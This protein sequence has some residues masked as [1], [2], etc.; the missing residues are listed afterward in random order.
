M[1]D[2]QTLLTMV[3]PRAV[4]RAVVVLEGGV[5]RRS[6]CR[7][8]L[9]PTASAWSHSKCASEPLK[10]RLRAS[11]FDPVGDRMLDGGRSSARFSRRLSAFGVFGRRTRSSALE[12]KTWTEGPRAESPALI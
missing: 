10:R 11:L 2:E 4:W 1:T 7:Q 5:P 12:F 8:Q 6:R 9:T 3:S